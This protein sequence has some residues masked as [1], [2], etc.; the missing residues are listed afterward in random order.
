MRFFI[1][2][3]TILLSPLCAQG[4]ENYI[5]AERD[6]CRL[7]M[8]LYRPTSAANGIT[9]IYVFGGGFVQGSMRQSDNVAFYGELQKRGFAVI[10][11][12]YRLGLKGVRNVGLFNPMPPFRAVN[13]ATE[14][15]ASAI[16]YIIENATLLGVDTAKIA[17]IGSSAGAITALQMQ[18]ELSNRSSVVDAIP[19]SFGFKAV[20]SLAGAVFSTKG[21]PKY[22]RATCPTLLM[23]GTEDKVVNYNKIQLLNIGMFGTSALVK[24]LKKHNNAFMSIRFEGSKH[25]VAEFPR[26]YCPQLIADF[27]TDAVAGK[28][29]NQLDVTVDDKFVRDN[30]QLNLS[31]KDLYK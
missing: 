2:L 19:E 14:D 31:R 10:A 12:D 18:Y 22:P 15:L 3:V 23:H 8:D 4:Q 1:I 20:V 6:T 28:F 30:F 9:A 25:E 13:I 16:G 24:Q 5:F 11:I 17:V 7:S 21:T 27:I 29:T 26:T